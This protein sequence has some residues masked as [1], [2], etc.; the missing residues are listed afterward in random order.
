MTSG[1]LQWQVKGQP[2]GGEYMSLA[3]AQLWPLVT[4]WLLIL[5]SYWLI[6]LKL[7][8]APV[9]V[10]ELLHAPQHHCHPDFAKLLGQLYHFHHQE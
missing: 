6:F 5:A 9:S 8:T 10:T 2:G 3:E 7:S 1:L 4:M